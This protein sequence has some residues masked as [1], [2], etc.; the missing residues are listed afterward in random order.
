MVNVN[1]FGETMKR[2]VIQKL[3]LGKFPTWLDVKVIDNGNTPIGAV[4]DAV[5]SLDNFSRN[6]PSHMYRLV[7]V[8]YT[9]R[10]PLK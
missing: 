9:T 2:Y 1:G 5:Q 7:V 3:E 10:S 8:L 6:N 4:I